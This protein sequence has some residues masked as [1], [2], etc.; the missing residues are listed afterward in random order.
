MGLDIYGPLLYFV[1]RGILQVWIPRGSITI[2]KCR[3]VLGIVSLP[4]VSLFY[5]SELTLYIANWSPGGWALKP[6]PVEFFL[7]WI[8][9]LVTDTLYQFHTIH[10]I[11]ESNTE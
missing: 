2:K 8:I 3:V 11:S 10:E 4:L 9:F 5:L 7:A 1:T 6:M